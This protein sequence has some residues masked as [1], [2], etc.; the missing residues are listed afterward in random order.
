M[1]I[2]IGNRVGLQFLE[3]SRSG[4]CLL[5]LNHQ[6]QNHLGAFAATYNLL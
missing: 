2:R 5:I 6:F 3:H 1:Q 4:G